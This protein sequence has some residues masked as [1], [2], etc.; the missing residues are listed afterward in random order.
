MSDFDDDFVEARQRHHRPGP[1][2]DFPDRMRPP[3]FPFGSGWAPSWQPGY[4]PSATEWRSA[5]SRKVDTDDATL[6][7]GP[8]LSLSGGRMDGPLHLARSPRHPD[9]AVTKRYADSLTPANGP[10]LSANGGEV[11]GDLTVCGTLTANDLN[12][13]Q[14]ARFN[15]AQYTKGFS[16]FADTMFADQDLRVS[17]ALAIGAQAYGWD[18]WQ[19]D[20]GIPSGSTVPSDDGLWRLY[21]DGNTNNRVNSYTNGWQDV[22]RFSDGVRLWMGPNSAALMYLQY[23]AGGTNLAI[24]GASNSADAWLDLIS[25]AGTDRLINSA[26]PTSGSRWQ[27]VMAN[28]DPETGTNAGSN[29]VFRRY[30]DHGSLIGNVL[31]LNRATGLATFANDLAVSGTETVNQTLRVLG[32]RIVSGGTSG[33]QDPSVSAWDEAASLNWG[34]WTGGANM[35]FGTLDGNGVPT[36]DIMTLSASLL[37]ISP[38]VLCQ[39]NLTVGG[40]LTAA[41]MANIPLI[42]ATDMD[43]THALYIGPNTQSPFFLTNAGVNP[44]IN[45]G[46]N[47]YFAMEGGTFV[48]VS[49]GITVLKIDPSGNIITPGSITAVN[50]TL[51][52]SLTVAGSGTFGGSVTAAGTVLT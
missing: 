52:G 20:C 39:G 45:M 3:E 46:P 47:T 12:V 23:S 17:G 5:F 19:F 15:F 14:T 35:N 16:F 26:S 44:T 41:A 38:A 11:S 21:V 6:Q 22:W 13:V 42:T 24:D 40:T 27:L 50:E 2:F 51:S 4:V 25:T 49:N 30:D 7:G 34:F 18:G 28:S 43:A 29:V 48:F 10:F 31:T 32:G 36:N 8:F 37:D 33:V 1:N 9:E